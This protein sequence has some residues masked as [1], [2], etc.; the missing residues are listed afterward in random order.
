MGEQIASYLKLN[1]VQLHL[2]I[3]VVLI[4]VK[5]SQCSISSHT[6]LIFDSASLSFFSASFQ[7]CCD[8]QNNTKD[9]VLMYK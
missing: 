3:A 2:D 4:V 9:D 7:C 6:S 8:P 1:A 5:E